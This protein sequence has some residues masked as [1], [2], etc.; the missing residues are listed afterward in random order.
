MQGKERA[1]E[2]LALGVL[3]SKAKANLELPYELEMSVSWGRLLHEPHESHSKEAQTTSSVQLLSVPRHR[4]SSV[5]KEVPNEA[6]LQ[7][8]APLMC[9]AGFFF[10][11]FTALCDRV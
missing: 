5:S 1:R 2:T 4:L 6:I 10:P 7:V 9:S 3:D 8:D 11:F